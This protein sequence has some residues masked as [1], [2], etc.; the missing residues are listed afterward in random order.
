MR[1][2][3]FKRSLA[4]LPAKAVVRVSDVGGALTLDGDAARPAVFIAGGIGITPFLSILRHVAHEKQTRNIT[5]FYSNRRLQDAAF[6]TEL[7]AIASAD[8]G[9]TF[10]PA[11]TATEISGQGWVG[12]T[13]RIDEAML[14]RHIP[15]L[16]APIYS[17]AG[18]PAMVE[19][20]RNLLS[21]L[22]VPRR[23]IRFEAFRGY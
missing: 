1:D 11:M 21:K 9:L 4:K 13:G 16:K 17:L 22:G 15:D 3:A 14:R 8:I 6:L 5:L 10:V 12:E 2:S 19:A 23:D 18:P 20:V 7:E